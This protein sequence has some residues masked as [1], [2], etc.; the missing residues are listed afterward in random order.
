VNKR[1]GLV[2]SNQLLVM[3]KAKLAPFLGSAHTEFCALYLLAGYAYRLGHSS[4]WV[5]S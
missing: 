2:Y 5:G 4:R 1:K 3:G